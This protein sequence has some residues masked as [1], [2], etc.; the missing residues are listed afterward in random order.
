MLIEDNIYL[1]RCNEYKT[2]KTVRCILLNEKNELGLLL[3]DR[4]D[5]FGK[6]KHYETPGGGL[7]ANETSLDALHRE[8]QE[9]VGYTIKN[10]VYLCS[11]SNEYNLLNRID[12]ADFYLAFIDEK[13]DTSYDEYEKDLIKGI[14]W[15]PLIDYKKYYEEYPPYMVS[16]IIYKRDQYVIDLAI[17]YLKENKLI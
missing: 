2:R 6:M 3:I 5:D 8:I 4:D 12:A 1:P 17:N 7:E 13:A 14:K 11:I 15:F 16:N 10:V 9:E